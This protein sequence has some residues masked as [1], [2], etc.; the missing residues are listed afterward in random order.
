LPDSLIFLTKII[1]FYCG[2]ASILYKKNKVRIKINQSSLNSNTS[3]N[4]KAPQSGVNVEICPKL[5]ALTVL[6]FKKNQG[7]E[8]IKAFPLYTVGTERKISFRS[9][10]IQRERFNRFS[11]LKKI[12]SKLGFEVDFFFWKKIGN[13]YAVFSWKMVQKLGK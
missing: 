10:C 11:S 7:R 8:T 1:G 2:T 9:H 4:P 6:T 5:P 12:I 3:N 13:Q